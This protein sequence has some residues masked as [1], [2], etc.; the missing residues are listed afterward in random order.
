MNIL[1]MNAK[2]AHEQSLKNS[3]L[4]LKEE[5]Q[6]SVEQGYFC[7]EWDRYL[8]KECIESLEKD[9]F[10]VKKYGVKVELEETFRGYIISW[11]KRNG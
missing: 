7:M 6:Y 8:G 3:Y 11:D 9:G 4:K 5:I 1:S 2:E 10:T